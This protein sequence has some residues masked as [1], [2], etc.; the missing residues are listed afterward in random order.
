M[1][2]ERNAE[3]GI[4]HSISVGEIRD[5]ATGD[6]AGV[7]ALRRTMNVKGL[8]IICG[9]IIA[10]FLAVH[11]ILQSQIQE[12]K[13]VKNETEMALSTL[14]AENAIL[15]RQ[16]DYVNTDEYIIS[17]AKEALSFVNKNDIRFEFSNPEA[18]TSY[19]RDEMK[20]LMDEKNT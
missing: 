1:K 4:Y 8:L 13:A 19:T 7:I 2:K 11:F 14:E 10:V 15:R 12:K 5:A 17:N 3:R 9:I 18:L 6:A 16:L 20:R